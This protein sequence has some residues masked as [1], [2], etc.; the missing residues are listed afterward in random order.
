MNHLNPETRAKKKAGTTLV[1]VILA[2]VIIAMLAVMASTA[3]YYPTRIV[4][5]DARRQVALFEANAE[6]EQAKATEYLTLS[7]KNYSFDAL[8]KTLD[9]ARV[10][11]TNPNEKII[12]ITIS[13]PSDANASPVVELI[14]VRTR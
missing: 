10:V 3:L 5:S 12:T 9:L 6:M 14:T 13:D 11:A 7:D 8:N 2:A 4:V 1:E